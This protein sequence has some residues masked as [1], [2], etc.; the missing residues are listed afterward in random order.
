MRMP[1]CGWGITLIWTLEGHG[2]DRMVY[3]F[4]VQDS[5]K[6]WALEHN[7]MNF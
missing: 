1:V 3:I 5:D 2:V 6:W 4:L 7:V